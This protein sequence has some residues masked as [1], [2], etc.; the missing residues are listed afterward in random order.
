MPRA[1][2]VSLSIRAY[3]LLILIYP[4]EHRREYGPWMIQLFRD[5][6]RDADQRNGIMG[7]LQLWIRTLWDVVITVPAEHHRSGSLHWIN[8]PV[9]P[10]P[11]AQVGLAV[12]PGLF[13][14]RTSWMRSAHGLMPLAGLGLCVLLGIVG[15]I[16]ERRLPVWGLTTLGVFASLL[17]AKGFLFFGP[18]GFVAV[19]ICL[20]RY[21]R[22]VPRGTWMLLG[23]MVLILG[24]RCASWPVYLTILHT[25][26]TVGT[27]S[28][29]AAVGLLLAKRNGLSAGLFIVSAGFVLWEE[30]LDLTY[31]IWKSPWGMVMIATL[32]FCLLL[33]SPLWVLRARSARGQVWGLLLPAFVALLGVA[34]INALVRTDVTILERVV[35]FRSFYPDDG[36]LYGCGA[37]SGYDPGPALIECGLDSLSL[38]VGLVIA[39]VLYRRID[40]RNASA[41]GTQSIGKAVADEAIPAACPGTRRQ[42]MLG[43]GYSRAI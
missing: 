23:L 33:V 16:R 2:F 34:V 22:H 32:A 8:Q 37:R 12:L 1:R 35:N 4:L 9:T 15:V 6:A 11:W 10:L 42:N 25:T 41:T 29:L 27:M 3:R 5:L 20:S 19:M 13:A 36:F 39:V 26:A 18:I 28:S 40:D 38:F 17:V 31:C 24:A 43:P 21:R 7:V 14:L 30:M